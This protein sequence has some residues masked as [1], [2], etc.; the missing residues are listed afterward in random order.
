MSTSVEQQNVSEIA[1]QQKWPTSFFVRQWQE[2][3]EQSPAMTRFLYELKSA[4][5]ENIASNVAPK[6]KSATGLF[7]SDFDLFDNN[8]IGLQRL[9]AFI[10]D[11]IQKV[12]SKFNGSE[13]PPSK[14]SVRIVDAWFHITNHGGFHDAH[15]HPNCSWCGIYYVQTGDSHQ[16]STHG[17]PNG[18]NRFYLPY[19]LGGSYSD[20]GNRY[21]NACYLDPPIKD[22]MLLLFPSYLWHSALPYSGKQDRIVIAFNSQSVVSR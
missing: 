16:S 11:T 7:E 22:G 12:V 10:V 15:G 4:H 3:A 6:A 2:H 20:Y 21:L 5:R 13:V 19:T 1:I 9:K 8:Q 14:I 18:A 17:A